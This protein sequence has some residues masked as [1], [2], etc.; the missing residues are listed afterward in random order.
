M[1]DFGSASRQTRSHNLRTYHLLVCV[2]ARFVLPQV[3]EVV[4]KA[5]HGVGSSRAGLLKV[6][7]V[8]GIQI[9]IVILLRGVLVLLLL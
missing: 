8:G 2:F 6:F 5:L 7:N 4:A 9:C 1:Q 3:E